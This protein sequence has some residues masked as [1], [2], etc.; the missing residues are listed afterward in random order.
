MKKELQ[1]WNL[2]F[3]AVCIMFGAIIGLIIIYAIT[4]EFNFSSLLGFITGATILFIINVIKVLVKN[5]NTPETDER[6]RKNML[7]FLLY[8]SNIFIG[9]LFI[10][11]G[12]ITI[13][14]ME[15]ISITYLWIIIIAYLWF[16]GIG[17]FIVSRK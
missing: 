14:G 8:A 1:R 5:D 9:V 6:T 10:T 2:A 7:K 4:G 12:I 16:S 17:G 13:L 3:M 15:S 11:L